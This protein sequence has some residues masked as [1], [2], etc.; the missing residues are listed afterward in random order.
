MDGKIYFRTDH[1]SFN[2][3]SETHFK[4]MKKYFSE[5][6]RLAHDPGGSRTRHRVGDFEYITPKLFIAYAP[7]SR[8]FEVTVV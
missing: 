6:D 4:S 3:A 2:V 8:E 1:N 5:L 7:L